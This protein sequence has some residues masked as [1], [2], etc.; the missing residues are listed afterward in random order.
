MCFY[1]AWFSWARLDRDEHVLICRMV[2]CQKRGRNCARATRR[3]LHGASTR[4]FEAITPYRYSVWETLRCIHICPSDALFEISPC[5]SIFF[6][7]F[8]IIFQGLQ[9]VPGQWAALTRSNPAC[10]T[11]CTMVANCVIG[12]FNH[13]DVV[14]R[15]GPR[16]PTSGI[17][18]P[19]N[20]NIPYYTAAFWKDTLPI[21]LWMSRPLTFISTR[22]SFPK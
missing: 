5:C 16:Y 14:C 22:S 11:I 18:H 2:N 6:F 20:Y 3:T 4:M 15:L 12:A 10:R 13:P 21:L 17:N 9:W 19:P 8:A 1:N 7:P